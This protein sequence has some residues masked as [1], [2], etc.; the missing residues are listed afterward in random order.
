MYCVKQLH[1]TTFV[2]AITSICVRYFGLSKEKVSFM[3]KRKEDKTL[4]YAIMMDIIEAEEFGYSDKNR[5]VVLRDSG[6]DSL[7]REFH[8]QMIINY[9]KMSKYIVL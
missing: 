9:P 2:S 7:I 4:L 8:H 1:M 5:M 3:I 6:I